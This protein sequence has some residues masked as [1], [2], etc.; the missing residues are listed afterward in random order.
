MAQRVCH[1][2]WLI[3]KNGNVIGCDGFGHVDLDVTPATLASALSQALSAGWQDITGNSEPWIT[4]S[5]RQNMVATNGAV[6]FVI[7]Q[8]N[9][10]EQLL[11]L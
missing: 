11:S 4:E 7:L 10:H 5:A 1:T 8:K 3:D 2:I 9:G 6:K